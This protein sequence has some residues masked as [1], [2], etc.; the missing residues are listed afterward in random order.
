MDLLARC[1][2]R[3]AEGG[4]IGLVATYVRSS[5]ERVFP[6]AVFGDL[7]TRVEGILDERPALREGLKL[8]EAE[9]VAESMPVTCRLHIRYKLQEAEYEAE[10][11]HILHVTVCKGM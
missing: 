9:Y 2:T 10:N 7:A 3:E 4:T 8:Q 1:A 5:F 6:A 11:R